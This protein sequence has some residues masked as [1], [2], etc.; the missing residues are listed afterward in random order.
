MK[1]WPDMAVN[2]LRKWALF[3]K[4]RK[5]VVKQSVH[6]INGDLKWVFRIMNI[7]ELIVR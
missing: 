1:Q 4:V 5:T 2:D 6:L 7:K 3:G